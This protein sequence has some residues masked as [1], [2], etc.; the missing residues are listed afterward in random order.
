MAWHDH[1]SHSVLAAA[2]SMLAVVV[3]RVE[4]D[5]VIMCGGGGGRGRGGVSPGCR[6]EV[7]SAT[8]MA[9]VRSVEPVVALKGALLWISWTRWC[10]VHFRSCHFY[11]KGGH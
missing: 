5:C 7:C 2:T 10:Y 4:R 9:S 6:G 1:K 3:G 11:S 8:L